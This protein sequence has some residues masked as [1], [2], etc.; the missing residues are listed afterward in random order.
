M[1][2]A[3]P[4]ALHFNSH[5]ARLLDRACKHL[6]VHGGPDT[7][8][9]AVLARRWAAALY[10]KLD[11]TQRA[12]VDTFAAGFGIALYFQKMKIIESDHTPD[13]LPALSDLKR[14]LATLYLASRNQIL[15]NLVQHRS[16][17]FDIDNQSKQVRLV[18]NFKG[19]GRV[20]L[21]NEKVTDQVELSSHAGVGLG[22]H[23]EPPYYCAIKPEAG[24][25]PAPSSL[26]LTARWNILNEPTRILPLPSVVERLNG[27]EALSLASPSFMYTRS[28]CLTAAP[29]EK[30]IPGSILQPDSQSG[31]AI[32]FSAYRHS[33]IPHSSKLVTD[34][35]RSLHTLIGSSRPLEYVLQPD[36]ALLIDNTRTLH[37]RDTVK[38]NRR[39]LIRL[40][41]YCS[42]ATPIVLQPDPLVV[43]G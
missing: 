16:F 4:T 1:I 37:G 43:R 9:T 26:I 11:A 17:A 29:D 33:P 23:T 19:G 13:Q 38:D 15:L 18:G 6:A 40:F 41:G 28:E 32:R 3:D 14:D 2:S 12:A 21:P 7:Q 27:I 25:S 8:G 22:L 30:S 24:H 31:F 35:F 42:T 39:L 5:Q 10:K 36:S 20:S 34:A